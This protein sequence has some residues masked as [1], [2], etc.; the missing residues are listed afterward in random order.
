M[1]KNQQIEVVSVNISELKGTIK[2][3]LPS[4]ELDELGV[5]KDA[6]AGPWHRQ[7]SLLAIESVE[8]FENKMERK[9]NC[10]EFGENITTKGMLLFHCHPFDRF[11]G[12]NI[13]LEVTQ[14]GKKCHGDGCEIFQKVGTCVMPKEGI[15]CRVINGG[16]LSAFDTFTYL[17]KIYKIGIITLSDRASSNIYEDKSGPA[18]EKKL[19]EF[20]AS[21]QIPVEITKCIIPDNEILLR[22]QIELMTA[23]KFDVV[24]TTGGT[25]IG[26]RDITPEV[27]LSL[28][29]KEIPGIM[30]AIRLKYG[31]KR[32]Q[33]LISR[34][35]A[36]LKDETL[37]FALPG[38]VNAVNEYVEE[39]L[40]HLN[41]LFL[42]I[43]HIDSH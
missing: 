17:P 3:P 39:I 35:V 4:I 42:M 22:D 11:V 2:T 6:H 5:Q 23:E 28:F 33:A 29:D 37:I 27:L 34:S 10:G 12:K 8:S 30:E 20:Y 41:H 15:F 9:I 13:E 1:D 16:T 14:I 31:A 24:F 18:I 25:G 7:V 26:P 21:K 32:I 40:P 36:G 43:H 38:S 19:T